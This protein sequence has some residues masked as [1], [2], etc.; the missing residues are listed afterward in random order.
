MQIGV[1][2]SGPS[3]FVVRDG[4]RWWLS[5]SEPDRHGDVDASVC[6]DSETLWRRWTRQPGSVGPGHTASLLERAVLSQVAIV[7]SNPGP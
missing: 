4:D 6:F 1:D 2:P 5:G 3:W 7:H